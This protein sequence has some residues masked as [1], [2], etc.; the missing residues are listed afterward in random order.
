[1]TNLFF[2][3][4]SLRALIEQGEGQWIASSAE[5]PF[6][7][8]HR[9]IF[10]AFTLIQS[11]PK[12]AK[13]AA[14]AGLEITQPLH[15]RRGL[16]INLKPVCYA[17][18]RLGAQIMNSDQWLG[19]FIRDKGF[20]SCAFNRKKII[21]SSRLW[22]GVFFFKSDWTL[23][24]ELELNNTHYKTRLGF[25]LKFVSIHHMLYQQFNQQFMHFHLKSTVQIFQFGRTKYLGSGWLYQKS[26]ATLWSLTSRELSDSTTGSPLNST[27]KKLQRP[28]LKKSQTSS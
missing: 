1:M 21:L 13:D 28:K 27:R 3:L 7:P 16:K 14:S 8:L 6:V 10:T 9:A 5:T 19:S 12:N 20:L 11:N 2:L 24:C 26:K 18:L 22:L 17:I 23:C 25:K 15:S 4:L